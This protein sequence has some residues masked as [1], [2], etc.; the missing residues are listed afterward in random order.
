MVDRWPKER[1]YLYGNDLA[2]AEHLLRND[3]GR[4]Q[5]CFRTSVALEALAQFGGL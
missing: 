2:L 4:V 1:W 3:L 5:H